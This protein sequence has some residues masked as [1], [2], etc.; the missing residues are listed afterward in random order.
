M[1][2][3]VDRLLAEK[4][5]ALL[6]LNAIHFKSTLSEALGDILRATKAEISIKTSASA[7]QIPTT[8]ICEPT[9]M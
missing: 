6:H 5:Y 2:L 3:L 4:T 1:A 7:K 9:P 8:L